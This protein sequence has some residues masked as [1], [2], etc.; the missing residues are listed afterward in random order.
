MRESP[1]WRKLCSRGRRQ[2]TE[3][4]KGK[5]VCTAIPAKHWVHKGLREG[6]SMA[7]RGGSSSKAGTVRP[8]KAKEAIKK[9]KWNLSQHYII[10]KHL[11]APREDAL[12]G[13]YPSQNPWLWTAT[14]EK[15][16]WGSYVKTNWGLVRKEL[17]KS[18]K[19][20]LG[21]CEE[22][23]LCSDKRAGRDWS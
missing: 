11:H 4:N 23:G 13:E 20:L 14:R 8:S 5:E 6:Q 15:K 22:C 1:M 3:N 9:K 19:S 17:D 12:T 21:V 16:P 18:H 2:S 7:Q 10:E